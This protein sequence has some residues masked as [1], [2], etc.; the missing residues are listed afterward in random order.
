MLK[1]Y[2]SWEN[3]CRFDLVYLV[4]LLCV[5]TTYT[6][7]KKKITVVPANNKKKKREIYTNV[8]FLVK[9]ICRNMKVFS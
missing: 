8:V 5:N 7:E 3:F 6:S 9:R 1:F 2:E 4:Q